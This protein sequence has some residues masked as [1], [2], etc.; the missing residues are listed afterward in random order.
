M[1]VTMPV[2]DTDTHITEPRDTWTARMSK[3]KWGDMVPHVVYDPDVKEEFWYLG[4]R[5]LVPACMTAQAGWPE[6][7][8]SH[9]KTFEEAHPGAYQAEAR[10]RVMDELGLWAQALYPNVGGF[11]SQ[12]WKTLEAA[13]QLSREGISAEVLDLR[14][15]RPLDETAIL[16]SVAKTRRAVIV[17]EGW[18]SGSLAAEVIARIVESGFWNLDMPPARVCTEEVPIPYPKHLEEAALPSVGRIVA[19]VRKILGH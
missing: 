16:A 13:E 9:P 12:L 10:L 3:Q 17:D 7:F 18:R 8:P 2:I 4:D 11:G 15:L 5:R 14:V 1:A 6:K 19:A